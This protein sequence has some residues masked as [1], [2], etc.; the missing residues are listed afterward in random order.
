MQFLLGIVASSVAYVVA[1]VLA[2]LGL[3]EFSLFWVG[4]FCVIWAVVFAALRKQYRVTVAGFIISAG[5]WYLITLIII[6]YI[7]AR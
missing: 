2:M 4:V 7:A 5:V 3:G 6:S 1:F